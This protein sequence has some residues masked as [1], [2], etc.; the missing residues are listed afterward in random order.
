MWL[1]ELIWSTLFGVFSSSAN[2]NQ[3]VQNVSQNII[4]ELFYYFYAWSPTRLVLWHHGLY[5]IVKHSSVDYDR[6][7]VPGT[8]QLPPLKRG[9]TTQNWNKTFQNIQIHQYGHT[10]VV[11]GDFEAKSG[12]YLGLFTYVPSGGSGNILVE[13]LLQVFLWDARFL[14]KIRQSDC[15]EPTPLPYS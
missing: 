4:I 9:E 13:Q 15:S 6:W 8:L 14:S 12:F 11:I 7:Q 5:S 3:A 10:K 2:A 1:S